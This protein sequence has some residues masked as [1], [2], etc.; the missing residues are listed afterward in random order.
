VLSMIARNCGGRMTP[1][2]P[3]TGDDERILGRA[4]ALLK[5]VRQQLDRQQFH[6]AL[7]EIWEVVGLANRYVD[8][9]APWALKKT[10]PAR[11]Q[12]V[13]AVLAEALR[14]IALV[15]QPFMPAAAARLLDQL[16][17]A[18]DARTFAAFSAPAGEV[19]PATPLPPPQGIFPRFVTAEAGEG[20]EPAR[21]GR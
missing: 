2:G 5:S 14:C 9:E 1:R 3:S 8:R 17:V 20:S 16:G 10:D 19:A 6:L 4:S 7:T 13:L 18:A 15:L 21:A 11:M 12:S